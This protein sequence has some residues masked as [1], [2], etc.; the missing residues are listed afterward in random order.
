MLPPGSPQDR[1][2]VVFCK[3]P[4]VGAVKTRLCPPL[5]PAA[6]TAFATAF[7]QDTLHALF[8]PDEWRL[9]AAFAPAEEEARL[10]ELLPVAVERWPQP[11]GDL[12][13]R[14]LAAFAAFA[15]GHPALIMGSD[16]PDLPPRLIR[17]AFRCLDEGT[18]L[19]LGPSLDG[20]YYL[21]GA[22]RP[23]VEIF[24]DIP[25]ST[26]QV[27]EAT[28]DRARDSGLSL[29]LLEPWEDVD[30][31]E[32][33]VRLRA[34]LRDGSGAAAPHTWQLWELEVEVGFAE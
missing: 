12:G 32:D 33:L 9:I 29:K 27:L 13:Q 22:D 14:L 3:V 1:R 25:W 6:A 16:T 19:V 23:Y 20:G 10:D 11:A 15:A 30:R 18:N 31:Y 7:L 4:Q 24:R 5:T 28:L 34:K 2:V 17:N 21:I 8:R 26:P